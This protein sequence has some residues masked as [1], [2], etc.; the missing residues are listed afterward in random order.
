M[1]KTPGRPGARG[2]FFATAAWALVGIGVLLLFKPS[3][4]V[5]VA[6]IIANLGVLALWV[7]IRTVGLALGG[8]GTSETWGTIGRLCATRVSTKRP[9]RVTPRPHGRAELSTS[10]PPR[11]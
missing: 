5:V 8:T 6:G 3:R 7:L 11:R 10:I 1:G 2:L 4:R 9:R